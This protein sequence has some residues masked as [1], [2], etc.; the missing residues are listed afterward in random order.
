MNIVDNARK[1]F[2]EYKENGTLPNVKELVNK[3]ND[4]AVLKCM[5]EDELKVWG[6]IAL[7]EEKSIAEESRKD[8]CKERHPAHLKMCALLAYTC[9]DRL[10]DRHLLCCSFKSE[11]S[12]REWFDLFHDLQPK[13]IDFWLE[14]FKE[15]EFLEFLKENN[16]LFGRHDIVFD[17]K[18][19]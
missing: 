4:Y 6:Y 16:N 12:K 9:I 13:V 15:P 8:F 17:K 14:T 1:A 11:E 18:G 7:E 5:F 10:S 3:N 2:Q 19:P